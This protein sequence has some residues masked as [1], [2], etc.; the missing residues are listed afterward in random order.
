MSN[1][2]PKATLSKIIPK[3]RPKAC[4]CCAQAKFEIH[5]R[6]V[7]LVDSQDPLAPAYRAAVLL[8]CK[9]CQ[10]MMMFS[11]KGLGLVGDAPPSKKK[12]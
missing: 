8:T 10:H 5:P 1:Q 2:I 4:P 3:I 6:M 11:A 9:N 7:A 12:A